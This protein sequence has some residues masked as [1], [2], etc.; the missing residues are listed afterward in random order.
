MPLVAVRS[1]LGLGA[2]PIHRGSAV[3]WLD[4]H[5]CAIVKIDGN[6]GK[7]NAVSLSDLPPEARRAV[8]ERDVATSGLPAGEYDDDA[9]KTLAAATPAM[10]DEA[11]RKASIARV[12]VTMGKGLP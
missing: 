11:E 9:H 12:L 2:I 5:G 6:G 7:R 1:I 10:R 8:I 4:R 3:E